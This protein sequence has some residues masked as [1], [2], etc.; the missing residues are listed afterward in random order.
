MLDY[1]RIRRF[2][3]WVGAIYLS[4]YCLS[5]LFVRSGWGRAVIADYISSKT[6]CNVKIEKTSLTWGLKIRAENVQIFADDKEQIELFSARTLIYGWG[7]LEARRVT[8]LAD[9]DTQDLPFTSYLHKFGSEEEF[10]DVEKLN[11][12]SLSL[13]ETFDEV[14]L[15]D[16]AIELKI[17]GKTENHQLTK[18]T[19]S[20]V[21][22]PN[23][24]DV[25]FFE[26]GDNLC[27]MANSYGKII[28]VIRPMDEKESTITEVVQPEAPAAEAPAVEAPAAEAPVAEAPAA[29]A[30]A[31]E[32]PAAEAPAVEAPAA[33]APAAEA[34]AAEAPAAEA[35]AAAAE[36]P[37]AEAPA[38]EAPAAEA[39]A[40]E[41]PAAEA[42][43]VK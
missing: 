4:L 37:A 8:V 28:S 16:V 35:P 11:E 32:T 33:E 23:K 12:F 38:A 2:I 29:E 3:L 1:R 27:W 36:A 25:F 20:I 31:A 41:A 30:P 17:N 40:A 22:L 14:I 34:P 13:F 15:T 24:K 39:P 19:K 26:L 9:F 42:P 5:C 10:Y 7:D 6:S 43:A 21:S 18:F